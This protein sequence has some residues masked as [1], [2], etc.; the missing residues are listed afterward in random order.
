M[1]S[2]RQYDVAIIGAGPAGS[3]AA[4]AYKHAEPGLQIALIDKSIFPRDKACGDGLGPGVL[5]VLAEL[6]MSEIVDGEKRVTD[7]E[8]RGPLS[9]FTRGPL[10]A[11]ESKGPSG[12]VME[13][14][15]FDARLCA[16]AIEKGAD[17][18]TGWRF[19][20][21]EVRENGRLVALSSDGGSTTISAS[22]LVGADGASSR[23]REDLG[24]ERNTDRHTGV[25]IRAYATVLTP[26]GRSPDG[27][28]LDVEEHLTPGYGWVFHC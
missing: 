18:F 23:V 25:G 7:V 15:R 26:N 11:L 8:V 27:L 12:V 2:P 20:G 14:R 4:I 10:P 24:V 16:A 28:V 1:R 5:A 21:S 9:T 3:A 22:L 6:G 17:D 13:R 19:R